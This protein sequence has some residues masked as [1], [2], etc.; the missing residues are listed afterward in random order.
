MK[1]QNCINTITTPQPIQWAEATDILN[2]IPATLTVVLVSVFNKLCLWQRRAETRG[3]MIHLD[4]HMLNDVGLSQAQ[5]MAE[6]DKPFWQ[7]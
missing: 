5:A 3:R 2:R 7:E 6:A 4:E 1:Q